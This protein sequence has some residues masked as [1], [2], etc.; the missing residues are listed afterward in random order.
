MRAA[1]RSTVVMSVDA[2]GPCPPI[3][4]D[5]EP[6]LR[7]AV[8]GASSLGRRRIPSKPLGGAGTMAGL[9]TGRGCD[10]DDH[11]R[12]VSNRTRRQC[13]CCTAPAP[14]ETLAFW[15]ALGFEVT[16]EQTQTVRVPGLAVEWVPAALR[17]GAKDLDPAKEHSGGCLV[18]V[19]AVASYHAAF[20]EA[21]RRSYGKVLVK[22]LPRMT[23]YR[24]GASRFSIVDPSGNTITF[25]Q[26]DEPEDLEY[27]GS[28]E[29]ARAGPGAR[30]RADP[31]RVQDGRP[32]CLPGARLGDA[33][34][35]RGRAGGRAG[36]GAGRPDRAGDRVG[37]G[38]P[39]RPSGAPDSRRCP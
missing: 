38:R 24:A 25:I 4:S 1:R 3:A 32:G 20:A 7:P 6:R 2:R 9:P 31:A 15:R 30:Q 22:G 21:M 39:G 17:P 8:G 29:L 14:E 33:P 34:P 10:H 13:R 18:M 12:T 5:R 11:M 26:R 35:R 27:G 28:T 19:D 16:Y 36:D 37:Q 23:R